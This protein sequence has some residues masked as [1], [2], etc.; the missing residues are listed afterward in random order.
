MSERPGR[1]TFDRA[2]AVT[3]SL[4]GYGVVA[5]AFYLVVGVALALTRDGFDLSRH[6]LS[7]LMLGEHGWLQAA[8]FIVTG[9]MVLAAAYGFIRAMRGSS[10]AGRAGT[11]L[12]IYGVCLVASGLFA[13]DPV[14][15][16]PPGVESSEGSLS[17]VLHFAFGAV[18]FLSL[19]VAAFALG[20]WHARRG[21]RRRAMYSRVAGA[22]VLIG[23]MAGGAFATQTA[24]I[25]MLWI[26][27][28][29]GF[30]WLAVA[31]IDLYRTVPHPDVHRR[32]PVRV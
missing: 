9:L 20:G 32:E 23:F 25:V 5:G 17:G 2:A 8:N 7:H 27:V 21:D 11:L 18:A 16:F 12:G 4:L 1:E 14:A 10:G 3:R 13:P 29:A 19:A 22:V 28:V 31:S 30:A 24:G 26:A 6:A 15:G